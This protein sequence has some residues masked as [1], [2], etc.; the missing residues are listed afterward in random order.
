MKTILL[1][2]CIFCFFNLNAQTPYPSG[3]Y[4]S[5]PELDK[6]VGTWRWVSGHDTVEIHLFKQ[7]IHYPEPLNYDVEALVGW[8]KYVKNGIV[9]ETSL[10][11]S[12]LPR[13]GGHST[14]LSWNQSPTKTYGVFND[15]TK[16]KRCDLY[17][18]MINAANTQLNW[19]L[20]EP[21]G[22]RPTGFQYGFTLPTNLT[23]TK[24]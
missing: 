1:S 21:R 12:G 3:S 8:H 13:T 19:T 5:K 14:I 16:G 6:F 9:I 2:I 23:L 20:K 10:Q 18:N 24:Q 17:L 4:N 22:I 15:L 7:A 11:F